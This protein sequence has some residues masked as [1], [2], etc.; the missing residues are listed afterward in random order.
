MRDRADSLYLNYVKDA[1]EISDA[2]AS[3]VL[4]ENGDR[5]W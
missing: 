4:H 1:E 2:I 5:K 3:T